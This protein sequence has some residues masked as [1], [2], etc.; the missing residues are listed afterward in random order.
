MK[1]KDERGTQ[2]PIPE[3]SHFGYSLKVAQNEDYASLS[4][5]LTFDL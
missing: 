5:H 2:V 4:V 1:G 3:S